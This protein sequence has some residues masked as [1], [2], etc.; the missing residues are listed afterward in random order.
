M[1]ISRI[2]NHFIWYKKIVSEVT[3]VLTVLS[4]SMNWKGSR[5]LYAAHWVSLKGLFPDL[6]FSYW[7]KK[8]ILIWI[9]A[10]LREIWTF[11]V[12]PHQSAPSPQNDGRIL[13]PYSLFYSFPPSFE[14]LVFI[15]FDFQSQGALIKFFCCRHWPL[16][17]WN[18]EHYL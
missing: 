9:S 8:N 10:A 16:C 12:I 17:A 18:D 4:N 1:W 3:K 14:A 5:Y 2:R 15:C 13:L 6:C 7:K 11:S